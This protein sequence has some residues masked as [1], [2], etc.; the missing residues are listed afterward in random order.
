MKNIVRRAAHSIFVAVL[1]L[2]ALQAFAADCG[3][4][5]KL[6]N[7][8]AAE[9]SKV[10]VT[11]LE[12]IFQKKLSSLAPA[13]AADLAQAYKGKPR[14]SASVDKTAT[15]AV[16]LNDKDFMHVDPVELKKQCFGP[17]ADKAD[18]LV[19]Q[20]VGAASDPRAVVAA[21]SVVEALDGA[22]RA[23]VDGL[24]KAKQGAETVNS[25]RGALGGWKKP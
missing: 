21:G 2:S 11:R 9:L 23:V 15:M 25:V 24:D 13:E 12:S 8:T 6:K 5:Q 3:V 18:S 20:K 1:A 22:A 16:K 10:R 14:W 19:D 7:K 17:A 4:D